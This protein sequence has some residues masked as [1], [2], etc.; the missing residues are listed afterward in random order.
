VFYSADPS[1]PWFAQDVEGFKMLGTRQ[2]NGQ[3]LTSHTYK[4]LMINV[5]M[6]L[7]YV[8]EKAVSL[9]ARTYKTSLPIS[10]TLA[11]TLHYTTEIIKHNVRATPITAFVN[12][13]GISALKLVPDSNIF[14]VRG[15]TITVRGEAKGIT[16]VDASPENPTPESPN[17]TYILPRPHSGT[18]VLGG[19]KQVGNWSG[20]PNPQT[21]R[22]ILERAKEFAPELLNEAR[23]FEVVSE[24]VGLRPG[25][26]GGARVEVEQVRS[27]GGHGEAIVVCHA[28][29]HAGAGY[30]NSIG[31]AGKVV[32]LLGEYFDMQEGSKAKL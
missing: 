2:I 27:P 24:Q 4:S 17:I 7:Q 23:E 29:G 13:T 31:S 25:R 3:T 28:Y 22:E 8:L 32:K 21:T 15:Q 14:P 16:T 19:T 12:A 5:P 9:G 30:Q 6:Y 20:E 26:R 10:S 11:G 18:T 1:P